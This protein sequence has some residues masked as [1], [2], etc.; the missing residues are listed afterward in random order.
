MYAILPGVVMTAAIG[1]PFPIPLAIVTDQRERQKTNVNPPQN[2]VLSRPICTILSKAEHFMD[3]VVNIL[4]FTYYADLRRFEILIFSS[5]KIVFINEK[6]ITVWVQSFMKTISNYFCVIS[7]H[8]FRCI[9]NVY[10][11]H[12]ETQWNFKMSQNPLCIT[13]CQVNKYFNGEGE[14]KKLIVS[15]LMFFFK[16]LPISGTTPWVSKPQ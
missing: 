14:W 4:S 16:I 15:E 6:S 12:R 2:K 13:T 5:V 9:Q 3:E 1:K 8:E 7:P 10:E 11:F